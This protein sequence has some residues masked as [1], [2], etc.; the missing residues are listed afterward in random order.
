M[1]LP[2]HRTTPSIAGDSVALV[3][4]RRAAFRVECLKV[5]PPF[6]A[7]SSQPGGKTSVDEVLD[8]PEA[9]VLFAVVRLRLGCL[10]SES[11]L[12]ARFS[13]S[14]YCFFASAHNWSRLIVVEGPSF[15]FA[16]CNPVER[17]EPSVARVTFKK[18]FSL[19]GR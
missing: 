16:G 19:V 2:K 17:P 10:G 15:P 9:F 7:L 8:D 18:L 3:D 4:A 11:F 6:A 5:F 14:S 13:P 1:R 12:R